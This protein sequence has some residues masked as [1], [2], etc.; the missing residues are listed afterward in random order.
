MWYLQL[1]PLAIDMLCSYGLSCFA[2]RYLSLNAY[3]HAEVPRVTVPFECWVYSYRNCL[4]SE[5]QHNLC[6]LL[7]VM[8]SAVALGGPWLVVCTNMASS[9]SNNTLSWVICTYCRVMATICSTHTHMQVISDDSHQASTGVVLASYPGC[10]L[11]ARLGLSVLHDPFP[12][13]TA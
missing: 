10:G 3:L 1:L 12:R 2:C 13:L 4:C 5:S 11:G 7:N 6:H 9:V 8:Q